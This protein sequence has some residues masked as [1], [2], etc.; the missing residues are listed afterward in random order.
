[1]CLKC[2][3]NSLMEVR[4]IKA[5]FKYPSP[6]NASLFPVSGMNTSA[7]RPRCG[8]WPCF[9]STDRIGPGDLP[10]RLAPAGL[11]WAC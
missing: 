2:P 6:N 9:R 8:L 5:V 4:R 11:A 1:M 7:W 3:N 10:R